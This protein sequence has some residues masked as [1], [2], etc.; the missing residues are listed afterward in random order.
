MN[1]YARIGH[2][3]PPVFESAADIKDVPNM[4]FVKIDIEALLKA[5]VE[6]P[7]DVGG[8]YV[9]ALLTMY[10]YMEGLPADDNLARLRLGIDIRTYRRL[11]AI[12]LGHP[13]CF[14]VKPSGRIS[15]SRFEEE[16]TAYVVEYRNR[17]EAAYAREAKKREG[18]ETRPISTG[19]P[20]GN[21]PISGGSPVVSLS[22]SRT[23]PGD[24]SRKHNEINMGDTTVL[25]EGTP[26]PDQKNGAYY[27]LEVTRESKEV[28]CLAP[29][30]GSAAPHAGLPR[31]L[32]AEPAKKARKAKEAK[33][34]TTLD[35]A[36]RLTARLG[37]ETLDTYAVDRET[38]LREAMRFKTWWLDKGDAKADWDATWRKW[39][40][41][42]FLNWPMRPGKAS[43]LAEDAFSRVEDAEAVVVDPWAEQRAEAAR[44]RA[45][46]DG[47]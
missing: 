7:L 39:C 4:H 3:G 23:H 28:V 12:L 31:L 21:R 25:A 46:E 33:P 35:P 37:E 19:D 43:L 14:T 13:G 36:W 2:N 40:G 11:K 24:L 32:T 16:V 5:L 17:Q 44:R 30:E 45:E 20:A 42:K 8:F 47:A 1:N 18:T 26:E 22:S 29:D 9:R 6:M 41:S 15:N 38:I 27:K 34:R 10:K